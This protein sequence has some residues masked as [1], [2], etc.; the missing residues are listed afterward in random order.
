MSVPMEGMIGQ[1]E[2]Q[3]VYVGYEG[4]MVGGCAL[5]TARVLIE[6]R[7]TCHDQGQRNFNRRHT[8]PK[9]PLAM[10]DYG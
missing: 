2:R 6:R 1:S 5:D 8:G 7:E 10:V 4:G 3:E 9:R